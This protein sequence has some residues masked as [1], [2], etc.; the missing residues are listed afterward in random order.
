MQGPQPQ[1]QG[2]QGERRAS[3]DAQHVLSG[4]L[5]SANGELA[6]TAENNANVDFLTDSSWDV[7]LYDG[8]MN[9]VGITVGATQ[10]HA[11]EIYQFVLL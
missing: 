2:R 6:I 1:P 8:D 7:S 11:Q 10:E 5:V 3:L 9:G 4:G